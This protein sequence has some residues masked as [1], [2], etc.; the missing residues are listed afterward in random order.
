MRERAGAERGAPDD[1]SQLTA[2]RGRPHAIHR[3]RQHDQP[4][5]H[6]DRQIQRLDLIEQRQNARIELGVVRQAADRD[7]VDG[8]QQAGGHIQQRD[9]PPARAANPRARDDRETPA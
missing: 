1:P 3:P 8:K 9:E 5:D 2:G 4:G 7:D 6:E